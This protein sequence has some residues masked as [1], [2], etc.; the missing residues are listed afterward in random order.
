MKNLQ[1]LCVFIVL[2]FSQISCSKSND[3]YMKDNNIYFNG[4]Q[5]TGENADRSPIFVEQRNVVFFI[6]D[7]KNNDISCNG[8]AEQKIIEYDLKT[9]KEKTIINYKAITGYSES[10]YEIER[11]PFVDT[12]IYS[13]SATYFYYNLFPSYCS[14][15][16]SQIHKFDFVNTTDIELFYGKLKAIIDKGKYK[17]KLVALILYPILHLSAHKIQ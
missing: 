16:L 8:I 2:L 10:G 13:N 3:L 12:L 7:I 6:R 17:D 4:K 15:E 1:T 14:G 5:L 11:A 9:D